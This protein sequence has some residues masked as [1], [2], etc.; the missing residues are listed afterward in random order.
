MKRLLIALTLG[1]AGCGFQP[2]YAPG[3]S[4]AYTSGFITVEP[5]RGRSGYV[6]RQAL[7][8]ELAIGLPNVTSSA[9]LNIV[10]DENLTR[11][12]F[13]P[14]GAAARS[15]IGARAKYVLASENGV[16][17][18]T[19]SVQT[20]FAVPDAPYGDIS[21]QTSASDRAMRQ[22]ASR[23]VDDLRLKLSTED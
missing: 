10:L 19:V 21:A 5:I 6:L 3:G 18:D 22:L 16:I 20:D 11:L 15:S 14:D 9:S 17:S 8:K 4:A 7:Q 23:I 12:A 2:V 13:K 1:L